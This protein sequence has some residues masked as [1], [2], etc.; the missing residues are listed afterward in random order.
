MEIEML[1]MKAPDARRSGGFIRPVSYK[2]FAEKQIVIKSS[3]PLAL[4]EIA[5]LEITTDL[6]MWKLIVKLC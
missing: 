1:E 2:N 6:Q 5:F 4:I 3:I